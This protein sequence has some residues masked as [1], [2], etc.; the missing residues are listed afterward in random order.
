[1]SA[2]AAPSQT[3][4]LPLPTRLKA[5]AYGLGFDLAGIATLGPAGTAAQFDSWLEHGYAGTMAYMDKY[6]DLR[7]DS[8]LPEPGMRSALVVALNYGGTQPT[9]TVARYARGDDY[10]R[11]I[12]DRLDSLGAWLVS[13]AGGTTRAFVDTGPVLERVTVTYTE[14]ALDSPDATTQVWPSPRAVILPCPSTVATL[15]ARLVYDTETGAVGLPA[16]SRAE[17][18]GVNAAPTSRMRSFSVAVPY[19][20]KLPGA[21]VSVTTIETGELDAP[22][23]LIFTTAR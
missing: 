6:A 3:S 1:M 16:P 15:V 7:R 4:R 19:V 11:V 13:E 18:A 14:S 2:A 20:R 22:G 10:H 9:G 23:A 8:T 12:W 21:T 5:Q 17:I